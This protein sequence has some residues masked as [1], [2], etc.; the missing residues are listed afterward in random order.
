MTH[1]TLQDIPDFLYRF[2]R[3]NW[4][5]NTQEWLVLRPG[6]P[7]EEFISL[8]VGLGATPPIRV[9]DAVGN[10]SPKFNLTVQ[11]KAWELN[12]KALSNRINRKKTII[13]FISA[14]PPHYG[15]KYGTDIDREIQEANT[16]L[17]AMSH[18]NL[19]SYDHCQTYMDRK[20]KQVEKEKEVKRL[21]AAK[22]IASRTT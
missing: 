3:S 8:Y 9:C 17:L 7:P 10:A 1:P 12:T 11:G 13:N 16:I 5:E 21:K 14:S 2:I 19:H 20:A 4:I 6:P 18:N 22:K 15:M